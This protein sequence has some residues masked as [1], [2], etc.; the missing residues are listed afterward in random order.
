MPSS[1]LCVKSLVSPRVSCHPGAEAGNVEVIQKQQL[2][3]GGGRQG[4]RAGV[5]GEVGDKTDSVNSSQP[6]EL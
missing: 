2:L 4:L 3:M 1:L 6:R 5:S